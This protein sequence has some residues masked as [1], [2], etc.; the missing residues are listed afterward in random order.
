MSILSDRQIRSLAENS[1]FVSPYDPEL[2][3]PASIDCRIGHRVI[4]ETPKRF[5]YTIDIQGATPEVP[6]RLKPHEFCL[7]ETLEEW[8]FPDNAAGTFY[9]KS[10][11]A[12]EGF[13]LAQGW[14][15]P[16]F[17]GVITI[18]LTNNRQSHPLPLYP[19]KR[20]GQIVLHPTE[21][22]VESS[23]NGKYQGDKTVQHSKDS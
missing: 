11:R 19:G 13:D 18:E 8:E 1:Y 23:Y 20:I 3:N 14:I 6:F 15:D 12:R 5:H 7:T 2:V 4:V 21:S 16:G 9:I 22:Q 10:S 17:K